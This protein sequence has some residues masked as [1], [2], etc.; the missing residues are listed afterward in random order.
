[1]TYA[2]LGGGRDVLRCAFS[3]A[4][5]VLVHGRGHGSWKEGVGIVNAGIFMHCDDFI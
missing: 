5:F 4:L 2:A 1:M 3:C